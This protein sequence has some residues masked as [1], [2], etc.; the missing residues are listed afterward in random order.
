MGRQLRKKEYSD[1]DSSFRPRH[2]PFQSG[3]KTEGTVIQELKL[4]ARKLFIAFRVPPKSS[5]A[6]SGTWSLLGKQFSDGR[7]ASGGDSLFLRVGQGLSA[8]RGRP[9]A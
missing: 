8:G 5:S 9:A 1:A 6:L 2:L 4:G 7:G 3:S